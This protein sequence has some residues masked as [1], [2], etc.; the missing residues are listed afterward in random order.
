MTD[1]K[2]Q[3]LREVPGS[4]MQ[5][6]AFSNQDQLQQSAL[7]QTT[8]HCDFKEGSPSLQAMTKPCGQ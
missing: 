2:G 7:S 4:L 5:Q 1:P 6:A 3:S 8:E